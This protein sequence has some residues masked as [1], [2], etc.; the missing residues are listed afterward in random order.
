MLVPRFTVRQDLTMMVNR[1]RIRAVEPD[2]SE[3]A[4]LAVSQQKRMAL[5]EQVTFYADEDRSQP[6]F[7]FRARQRL[8]VRAGHDVLDE[9][10]NVLGTFTKR[11]TA[12]LLRSTWRLSVPGLEAEGRERRLSVAV[13]RRI[14]DAVPYIGDVWVPWVFHFDFVDPATGR[15]VLTSERRKSVR[16]RYLVEVPDPRVDFRVAASMAVALD[17]L[18]SR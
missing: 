11:F 3:G 5:K 7:S 6:V 9:H 10:G 16:D 15:P 1:Y 4:L 8:D 2:G 12:S 13:L 14:W 18:Q 17:A